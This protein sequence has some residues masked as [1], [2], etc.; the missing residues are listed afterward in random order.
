MMARRLSPQDQRLVAA[1][2]LLRDR[3]SFVVYEL[4]AGELGLAGRQGLAEALRKVVNDLEGGDRVVEPAPE[5][6]GLVPRTFS[7]SGP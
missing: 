5:P 3:L 4:E 7:A 6:R 2:T 1:L